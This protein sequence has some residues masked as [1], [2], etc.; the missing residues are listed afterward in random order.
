VLQKDNLCVSNH[1]K[2]TVVPRNLRCEKE[3]K[4]QWYIP[5]KDEDPKG[6]LP[7]DERMSLVNSDVRDDASLPRVV[8]P[9]IARI[10]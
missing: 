7:S 3:N 2:R 8:T 5:R 6:F 10:A 1:A 9:P 4:L